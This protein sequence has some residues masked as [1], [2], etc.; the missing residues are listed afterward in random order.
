VGVFCGCV[1]WVCSVGVFCG[2]VLWVCSVGVFFGCVLWV[3][4]VGVSRT[5]Y[6]RHDARVMT[7]AS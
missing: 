5:T 4:S 3:C 1:L 7:C 6:M 2:C